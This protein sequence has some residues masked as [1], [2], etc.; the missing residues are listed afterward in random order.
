MTRRAPAKEVKATQ[1]KVKEETKPANLYDYPTYYDLVFGSD[2]EA[3]FRF[4][5][6]VFKKFVAGKTKTLFEPAC[7]TGRLLFR[8]ARAGFSVSG[9]DLN[10]RAV[11]FCR[12]RLKRNNL[13]GEIWVGDMADFQL[14][15][16]VDAAFNTINSFRHLLSADLAKAHLQCMARAVRPGGIYALG[17]HLT[18]TQGEPMETES[19]AARRGNLSITTTLTTTHRDLKKRLERCRMELDVYTPTEHSQIIDELQFRTYTLRQ[20]RDLLSLIPEFEVAET[21]DFRY[22]IKHP[23]QLDQETEDVVLILRRQ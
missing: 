22:Q 7:G 2:W 5:Q 23:Q 11:E 17:L 15:K 6:N 10:P 4:L 19:W 13:R 18:P 14:K 12:E 21:F 8:L 16:P 9:L 3:E 1:T 20:L